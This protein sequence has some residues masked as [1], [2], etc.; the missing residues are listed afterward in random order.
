MNF[1]DVVVGAALQLIGGPHRRHVVD[2][3]NADQ[4]FH[5][6]IDG[7][8][9][10]PRIAVGEFAG[11]PAERRE[12]G[13]M[14]SRGCADEADARRIDAELAGFA[15]GKLHAGEHVVHGLR[16]G[17]ALGRQ[18]IA[19]G[20]QRDA[21]RGEIRAPILKRGAHALHPAAAVHGDQRRRR[22]RA[23]RQIEVAQKLDAVM[24]G[25]GDAVMDSD[26]VVGHGCTS[27]LCGPPPSCTPCQCGAHAYRAKHRCR[28]QRARDGKR[29]LPC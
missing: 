22:L 15:A 4:R 16:I 17:L 25:V 19:D 20:K 13:K 28:Q 12:R 14:R 2:A 6:G 9:G 18:P 8:E 27:S 5:S 24:I 7:R 29:R 1:S 10:V 26:A 11:R 3:V 21:A 23:S